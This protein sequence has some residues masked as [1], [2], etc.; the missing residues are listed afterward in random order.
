MGSGEF[1]GRVNPVMDLSY[2]LHAT[3][4]GINSGL[5]GHLAYGLFTEV[6]RAV[7]I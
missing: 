2:S 5:I 4:T 7:F 3:E 6:K 1:K